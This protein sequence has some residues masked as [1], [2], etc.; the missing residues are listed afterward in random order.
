[1]IAQLI[2]VG[3][4]V[5]LMAAPAVLGMT[6]PAATNY[7]IVGPIIAALGGVAAGECTRSV[8]FWNVPLALWL[9]CSPLTMAT[10]EAVMINSITAGGASLALC[11]V[12]G[13]V[14]HQYGGGWMALL[15]ERDDPSAPGRGPTTNAD[16][17]KHTP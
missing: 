10:P 12:R 11:F 9:L 1:M 15:H 5:W 4:G 3:V 6:D 17:H 16:L 7:H 2:Q 14:Q 13:R 8:R